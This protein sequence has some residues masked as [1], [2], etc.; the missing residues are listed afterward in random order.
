MANSIVHAVTADLAQLSLTAAKTLAD[1]SSPSAVTGADTATDAVPNAATDA[2]VA[3]ENAQAAA[4]D[5]EMLSQIIKGYSVDPWFQSVRNTA[6]LE[7]YHGLYYRGDALV[8]PD[9]PELKRSILKELHD[10]NYSGH[11]G[12]QRTIHHVQRMYWWP[13]MY[14]EIKEYVKGCLICQQDKSSLTNPPGKLQPLPIPEGAWDYVTADRIVGLPKTKKGYTAILVVVDRLTKMTHFGPCKDTSTA[15]ELAQLFVDMVWKHHGLPLR[16]T[17]DRGPEFTNKFIAAMCEI[18]GTMHCKSTAYHPQSDGQTERMNKVLEDMLRHYINPK[19]NNW[20]ELLAPAEF[21][22]NNA[23]QASIQDT[24]FYLNSG[25]HPRLPSDLNLAR[26]P[27]KDPAA[28][29]FIGNIQKAIA[30]AKVCMKAAQQRQKK[31]A[32]QKRSDLYFNIGDMAWLSSEHIA[33]KAIGSR[34]MLALWLGPFKVTAKVGPVNYTLDIPEHYRIHKTF[35][36]SMLRLA[37]DNGSGN[38]RPPILMIEGQEEFELEEI[39]AHRPLHKQKGDSGISYLVK[40]V[41]YG[42]A[43]NSWEPERLL[44][45]RAPETI[46]GMK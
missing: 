9:I 3:A 4:A 32:D 22:I 18:V 24:P 44:K 19:Q 34:K 41:G 1:T 14:S 20:E 39:L 38:R 8:V 2:D 43:Y 13:S 25:R 15:R 42:P 26:K 40:W 16:L 27:S 10:A 11:V 6:L 29:D 28:A 5:N 35:H 36:V 7:V 17:T 23:Y 45:Q 46:T 21:A 33:I 31:Y 37:H 12:Y 30:R